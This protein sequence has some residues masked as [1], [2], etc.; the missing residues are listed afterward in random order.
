MDRVTGGDLLHRLAATDRPHSDLGLE[1]G[2][3]VRR[4]FNSCGECCAYGGNPV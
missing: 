4:L 2:T 1:L 3:L